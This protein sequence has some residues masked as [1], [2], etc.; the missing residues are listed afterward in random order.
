M[1]LGSFTGEIEA[2]STGGTCVLAAVA[3]IPANSLLARRAGACPSVT[4]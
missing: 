1:L 2:T 4:L 3:T